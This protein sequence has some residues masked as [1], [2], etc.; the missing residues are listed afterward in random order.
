MA[1]EFKFSVLMPIYN[2]EKYLA[3]SIDSLINQ[4]IGFEENIELIIVDDG[5]P[6]NSKEI[7]LKYQEKYPNNIKVFSKSNGGQASAFNFGLKHLNGKYVSFLDSD[8]CLSSNALFEV[9]DFFE[10]HY[11]EID[12]VS[13]PLMFFERRTGEHNLNY[14]FVSTRVIDLVKE[15]YY[16]QLSIA[17]SF[18]KSEVLKNFEF[19]TELIAGYDALMVNKILLM[20]KKIGVISSCAYHY[21][22]RLDSTSTID[23]YK[24]N[25]K[26]FTHSLK[27][28]DINLIEYSKEKLGYVPLFIQYVVAYNVQWFHGISDFPESFKKDEINEFWETFY[29]IL[30]HVDDSVIKDSRIIRKRIVR[31][32]LMYL[33]NH[34]DFHI[35]IVENNSKIILKTEDFTI[36]NLHNHRFYI[37][38]SELNQ[39]ILNL[40][41]TFTSLCDNSVLSLEAIK[42]TS[43]GTTKVFKEECKDFSTNS[44]VKRILG[45][46][47]Q[48]KH[49][50]DLKIPIEKDEESKIDLYLIYDENNKKIKINNNIVFRN[51]PSLS[52]TINYFMNDSQIAFF[53]DN[54]FY[55]CPFSQEKA[56]ELREEL[57]SHYQK[58]L[59]DLEKLK[60]DNKDLRK[61]NK[62]LKKD[63]KKSKNKNKE[64]LNSLSWK[65]TKPLRIPKQLIK[66][67]KK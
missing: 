30:N 38:N 22:K 42:T 33:K 49:Y 39:G 3:E 2:V 14:K 46:N 19:N 28:L 12:L 56:N 26:F 51:S 4:S 66:K 32:F 50:F 53:K 34:Q 10:K 63:L 24:Q 11:N 60:K 44:K 6:D 20:K 21:R 45:I 15:P 18:V 1:Y 62:K 13:I 25:E 5:S 35:D 58:I 17:S 59:A 16:P 23:N 40:L 52:G 67:M 43:D 8:D 65:I 55:V 48:F 54:S 64:I 31:Y 9:Y 29:E 36:N 61:E 37:D 7:A 41:G 57:I 27:N 47:W